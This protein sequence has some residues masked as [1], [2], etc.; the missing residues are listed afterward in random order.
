MHHNPAKNVLFIDQPLEAIGARMGL[1]TSE[2]EAMLSR[3]KAK[4]LAARTLRATPFVDRSLYAGWNAMM[5]SA[6]L[7]AYKVL[8]LEGARDRA[9]G[10]LDL[11]LEYG[12]E[13]RHGVAHV[14]AE[15]SV[16]PE[17]PGG[18][19]RD[20]TDLPVSP[21][22][23]N[24]LASSN[25]DLLDDQVLAATALLDAFEVTG[26]RRYFDR[27]LELGE[28]V[29]RRYWDESQGGFFDTARDSAGR[30]GAL[31][32][33]RKAIQDSP[34]PAANSVAAAMLDRLAT[35]DG[36]PDFREKAEKTLDLFA[37]KA[38]EY[39][40]Y[41]GTYALALV[42]HLRPPVEVVVIGSAGSV[43]RDQLLRAAYDARVAGVRVLAFSPA[44]IRRQ[45]HLPAGLA[46]TLP[47]L[48]LDGHALALVCS[49][50]SCQPAANSPEES[51]SA[52]RRSVNSQLA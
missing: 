25:F 36:R 11:F 34:T 19:S 37:S 20:H 12:W 14:L 13:A 3:A 42:S 9:L 10:A 31:A 43:E 17:A 51:I 2:I 35:L 47:N 23:A 15:T 28:I 7:E 45:G 52:L 4:L 5:A 16:H 39:G 24:N 22:E 18:E 33:T 40:L 26:E 32:I 50:A 46:A 21:S 38:R 44:S 8:G 30:Q 29:L 49:G 6:L 27:A 1:G 48:P 41:A